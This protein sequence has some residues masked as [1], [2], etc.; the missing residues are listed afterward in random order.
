[1]SLSVKLYQI[2]ED[3][4]NVKLGAS[5]IGGAIY[6]NVN[7]LTS[8]IKSAYQGETVLSINKHVRVDTLV[9][10]ETSYD[11][12]IKVRPSGVNSKIDLIVLCDISESGSIFVIAAIPIISEVLT[13]AA[14]I[15]DIK[16]PKMMCYKQK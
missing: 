14:K 10:N 16:I 8:K 9:E 1:M 12:S 3:I 5:S 2:G 7:R 13:D 6:S 4:G 15:I 11:M